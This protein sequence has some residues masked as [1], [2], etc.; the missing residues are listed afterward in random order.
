MTKAIIFG[1]L[2]GWILQR[3][4]VN[5]FN[6]IGGFAML[7]DF[8]V[9]KVLLTAIGI[10]SVLLFAETKLGLASLHIKTFN[11]TGVVL[12][13]C[14]FGIGMAILGYC[15][16]TLVVS[17]GEGAI[18]A[19]VGIIGGL[20]AGLAYIL[21]YANIKPLLGPDL[22]KINLYTGNPISTGII[23]L[24]FGVVLVSSAVYIDKIEAKKK[25]S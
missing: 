15:P 3:S 20:V 12:G 11:L 14:I 4:R 23:V 24:L 25:A 17:V 19:L 9:L 1:V 13:A 5:T 16:G 6:K 22:G 10:G 7:E 21:L 8:T 18:D 2:F